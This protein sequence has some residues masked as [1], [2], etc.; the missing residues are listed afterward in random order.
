MNKLAFL[1]PGAMPAASW[2]HTSADTRHILHHGGDTLLLSLGLVTISCWLLYLSQR[3]SRKACQ[4]HQACPAA[5]RKPSSASRRAE[6]PSII[7]LWRAH[8]Q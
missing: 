6:L 1:L 5:I 4:L 3:P 2:A 7:S 8:R